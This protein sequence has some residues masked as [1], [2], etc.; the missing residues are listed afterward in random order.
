MVFLH[1]CMPLVACHGFASCVIHHAFFA[2]QLCGSINGKGAFGYNFF[3]NAKAFNDFDLC[4]IFLPQ[5]YFAHLKNGAVLRCFY[6]HQ[7]TFPR[8]KHCTC[9]MLTAFVVDG[10]VVIFPL[11]NIPG[12]NTLSLF[13]T[14]ARRVAV[15]VSLL[16]RGAIKLMVPSTFCWDRRRYKFQFFVLL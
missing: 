4:C 6:I 9:R 8:P 14:V 12:F 1:P 10:A 16:S 5:C 7:R 11:T 15:R 3:P 13:L 2:L